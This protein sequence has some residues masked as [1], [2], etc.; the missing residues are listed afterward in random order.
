MSPHISALLARVKAP[1]PK[2][3]SEEPSRLASSAASGGVNAED[4]PKPKLSRN[5]QLDK[6]EQEVGREL[7]KVA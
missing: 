6:E 2:L 1:V 4:E 7:E 5:K 3:M